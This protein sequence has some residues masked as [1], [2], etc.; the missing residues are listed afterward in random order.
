[1]ARSGFS[2]GFGNGLGSPGFGQFALFVGS[3]PTY[4]DGDVIHAFNRRRIRHV[5]A[6]HICHVKHVEFNIDG[7]NPAGTLPDILLANTQKYKWERISQHLI[8]RT[9]LWTLG[10]VEYGSTPI[11]DP[12]KPGRMI[13]CH[14]V[15]AVAYLT[16]HPQHRVFGTAGTEHFYGGGSDGSHGNL[17]AVW[18]A[19]ETHT[20]NQEQ[21]FLHWPATPAELKMVLFISVNDFDN[22]ERVELESALVD[23][24]DPE[25][26]VTVKKRK[27]NVQWR[28]L[29]DINEGDVL[30]PN[31]AVDIRGIRKHVRQET[32]VAK[33]L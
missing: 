10:E 15:E 8:R 19:I 25:N 12:D 1:M 27:H 33:E 30:N 14:V 32:V 21:D 13:H 7:L 28:N 17:D 5:H 31:T 16:K 22:Q 6:E 11:E 20:A 9:N 4:E 29:R 3:H 18:N 23:G 26:P 24:T 2:N